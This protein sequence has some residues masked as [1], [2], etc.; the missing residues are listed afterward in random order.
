MSL[1]FNIT[2][3]G[4]DMPVDTIFRGINA[5]CD[6]TVE[7]AYRPDVTPYCANPVNLD[8]TTEHAAIVVHELDD[9]GLPDHTREHTIPLE[10]LV[11]INVL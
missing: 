10:A 7:L 5:Y 1:D 4:D 6:F 8:H 3:V 9:E 2:L 11:G